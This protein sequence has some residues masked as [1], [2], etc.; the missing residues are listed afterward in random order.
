MEP[1]RPIAPDLTRGAVGNLGPIQKP[2]IAPKRKTEQACTNCRKLR[3]KCDG[4]SP[5]CQ[6][7]LENGLKCG[8]EGY[9]RPPERLT[10]AR[11]VRRIAKLEERLRLYEGLGLNRTSAHV[12]QT[13]EGASPQDVEEQSATLPEED[14]MDQ[15]LR[16]VNRLT[17]S[18]N[19]EFY[20]GSSLNAIINDVE[21]SEE[22]EPSQNP[23]DAL[24]SADN[25]LWSAEADE[26]RFA[27]MTDWFLPLKQTADWYV[28]TYFRTSHNIYPVVERRSFMRRYDDFWLGL[29]TE[30][31]IWVG[32]MYM[33]LALG[34]QSS[35]VDPDSTTRYQALQR[36]DGEMCFLMARS[37]FADVPFRGGDISAA[38]SMFLGFV[39]LYNQQ[40]FHES[41]AILGAATRV[42]YAIGLHRKTIQEKN[43]ELSAVKTLWWSL[44]I[45]E[46]ELATWSGRPC[47]IQPHEMDV[48]PFTLE[49]SPASLQYIEAMRQFS[50]LTWDAY[51]K[52]Y[53]LPFKYATP[54]HR[55]EALRTH[56]QGFE[57][58]YDMWVRS[59]LWSREPYGLILRLRYGNIRILL[60]RAFLNL[61]IL[62]VKK[63]KEVRDELVSV[64]ATCVQLALSFVKTTTESV[65]VTS[66]GIIQAALFHVIGYLW[67]ATITLLLYAKNKSAHAMLSEK[68]I[69][70]EDTMKHVK[71]AMDFFDVHK[72]GS[73]TAQSAVLKTARLIDKIQDN[74]QRP[75][76][77]SPDSSNNIDMSFEPSDQP[78]DFLS[79]MSDPGLIFADHSLPN[80]FSLSPDSTLTPDENQPALAG[81]WRNEN[82]HL[83]FYGSFG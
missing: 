26:L 28:K 58:W 16:G 5:A 34:H 9:V 64:A 11:A 61:T 46:T 39:W 81:E 4:A 37:T 3:R 32:I 51:E 29:S 2:K 8:Y 22:A 27:D 70:Y 38:V 49:T 52:V 76:S 19:P 14:D 42:G 53:G 78:L 56:D 73:S 48:Q 74:H 12:I 25:H 7:C 62:R 1:L 15:V 40:R 24:V 44:F 54:E 83:N 30:G 60:Y 31:H 45:Y 13:F 68:G 63:R 77:S 79:Q 71:L 50:H 66:S 55:I 65:H 80:I 41:Y 35:L 20:G 23:E 72:Y 75:Q 21:A 57:T 6:T 59:D 47:A 10:L 67:N 17:I 43:E 69:H 82:E 33:V 36:T 18:K